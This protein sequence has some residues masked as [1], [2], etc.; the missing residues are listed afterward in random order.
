VSIVEAQALVLVAVHIL[1][2]IRVPTASITVVPADGRLAER[3]GV[4]RVQGGRM[5][6]H[7]SSGRRR[8]AVCRSGSD[9]GQRWGRQ[10]TVATRCCGRVSRVEFRAVCWHTE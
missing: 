4:R 7:G 1:L 3:S 5:A 10:T 6:S 2:L 9:G 8:M